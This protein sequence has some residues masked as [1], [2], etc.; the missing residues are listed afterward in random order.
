MY[1]RQG[2]ERQVEHHQEPNG[3][4]SHIHASMPTPD[5]KYIAVAD[6]GLDYIYLYDAKTYQKVFEWKAPE[7]SGPRQLRFSPDGKYLYMVSELS[8]QIFVFE[9]QPDCI[10]TVSYT[11]LI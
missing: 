9:Y 10:D 8:C 1:K 6:C 3:R 5:G 11:H 4:M 7:D 2:E